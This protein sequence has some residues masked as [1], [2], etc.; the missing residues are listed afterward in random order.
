MIARFTLAVMMCGLPAGLRGQ[1]PA[2][3]TGSV[4][5]A[6][7]KPIVDAKVVLIGGRQG[8]KRETSSNSEGA[9]RFSDV[10]ADVY[11]VVGSAQDYSDYAATVQVGAGQNRAV[12]LTLNAASDAMVVAI[13][14][15][16]TT[17]DQGSAR[18]GVNVTAGEVAALP[19]NGRQIS[20]LYMLTPGAVISGSGAFDDVR[21]SGRSNQQNIIRFDG[22]EATSIIDANPGNLNGQLPS[23]FRLQASL[24][25]VQE[26]RAESSGYAAESGAGAGGQI[27]VVTRSGSN[28]PHGS[29]FEYLRNN[30]LDARNFFDGASG[31]KLR[32]NQFGGSMGG[33]AVKDKLFFFASFEGLRQSIDFPIVETT[34]SAAARARAVPAV[35]SLLQAFPAGTQRSANTDFDVVSVAGRS[36]VSEN[37]GGIRFDYNHSPRNRIFA[38]YFRDQ[39]ESFADQNS[40]RS[41]YTVR[42]VPQNAVLSLQQPFSAEVINE[43]KFGMNGVKTRVNGIAP[44]VPGVDLTGVTLNISGSVALGSGGAAGVVVP[45]GLVRANSATNGRGQPYT[46]YSL[47]F[48]DNLI[49]VRGAH[50]FRFGV[51][52]RPIRMYTDRLGGITYTFSN[53]NDFLANRPSS[54]QYLG[55][56]SQPSPFNN[57]VTGN[58]LAKQAYYSGYAQDEWKLKPNLTVSL[59]LRYEYYSVLREDKHRDVVFNP[60]TGKIMP[61]DT[62][63]YQSSKF[64][65][66]PRLAIS[67]APARFMNRT[68]F[69]AGAGYYYGPGQAEDQIQPIESDRLSTTISSGSQLAYP[70]NVA[71]VRA[72]YDINSPTLGFQPRAYAPG[73]SIPEK[74]LSYTA[75]VQQQLPLKSVLT[76]AYV[77]SQG[78]NLF[79]RGITNKIVGI[80]ANPVSGAAIVRREFGDRFA[81]IDYKTSGGADSYNS[82]QATLNRRFTEDLTVGSQFT[83]AHSIGNSGGSNEANTAGN[84]FSFAADRGNNNFDVRRSLNLTALYDVPF[85]KHRRHGNQ[86][87][88]LFQTLFGGWLV[89]GMMNARSGL[90][91]DV[92]ITRPDVAYLDTRTGRIITGPGVSSDGSVYTRPII[93]VPGGGASRNVRRPD[94]VAGVN[95]YIE[96]TSRLMWLNPAA[97][98]IPQPGQFGNLGRNALH[99]PGFSQLDYVMAK[100]F[101]P[102]E[103]HTLEFRAEFFNIL[104]HANFANP[105]ASL[106]NALP[107]LQPGLAFSTPVAPSFGGISSTVGK[108]VG[109]GT[110]RQIQA[111]L[112]YRF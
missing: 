14:T 16:A 77:G 107:G 89:G 58:R 61:P 55:D 110:S 63:F 69:R 22:I 32:L 35:Q 54:I 47:S 102:R 78:R 45:T 34:P 51:E 67:F 6:A 23:A 68:V 73:Y 57:G 62:P 70:L 66:G 20:Q 88:I 30:V 10:A 12:E 40:S 11:Q 98:A 18:M 42:A 83:W 90:P 39:G 41:A 26:F 84:N 100:G 21:F 99:G 96:G 4:R 106:P 38:R 19:L 9:F 85:G 80:G 13:D 87:N 25:N 44:P 82:L 7:G 92:L 28:S 5:D 59:G 46:N 72:G 33:P 31:S 65:F 37:S 27:T 74:I 94:V 104:N 103:G 29:V 48:I 105:V 71:A 111:A 50:S 8:L 60:V 97:F 2:K 56:V 36:T 86:A 15:R 108:T 101:A 76:L 95:P 109:L 49:V 79:L 3:I 64:N 75:S 52:V 93:N 112:R 53:L 24:E 91:V 17:M 81:E 43:V 1:A